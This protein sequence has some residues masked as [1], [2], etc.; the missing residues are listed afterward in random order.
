MHARSSVLLLVLALALAVRVAQSFAGG[1]HAARRGVRSSALVARG[2]ARSKRGGARPKRGSSGPKRGGARSKRGGPSKGKRNRAGAAPVPE[3]DAEPVGF[4]SPWA[5]EERGEPADAPFGRDAEIG[6]VV[7]TKFGLDE[8]KAFTFMGGFERQLPGASTLPEIA[9]IGRSN[10]GKSSMLNALEG[11]NRPVAIVSKTPG[12]TREINLFRVDSR[13]NGKGLCVFADLPGYGYA[14]MSKAKQSVISKSLRR[15][16][17]TR[18]QLQLVVLLV[19]S[20]REVQD[21]DLGLA[22][23]FE[24]MD[25]P[26]V[27]LATKVDKLKA[28]E[29]QRQIAALREG[30][31]LPETLPIPTSTV[32]GE[33]L[34]LLWTI[35][36]QVCADPV[37]RE[38]DAAD[39]LL[40][41]ED[42]APDAEDDGAWDMGDGADDDVGYV[43]DESDFDD[44]GDD[45][46]I[47]IA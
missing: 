35:I 45:D 11:G 9:F 4:V 18:K 3:Q 23:A 29:Q 5:E 31:D 13:K 21:L 44:G 30:L 37:L 25:V 47:F 26:F 33:G 8:A 38:G 41:E 43:F 1:L 32:S 10:V 2:A 42:G 6:K 24:D 28:H 36:Q 14:K 27:V 22:R 46:E 16:F 12:R 34:R 40:D 15:Y 7:P 19:D 39:G 20:R 17:D